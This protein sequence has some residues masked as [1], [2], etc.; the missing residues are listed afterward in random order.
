VRPLVGIP[1]DEW[2][3]RWSSC[4][5]A[6]PGTGVNRDQPG[7]PASGSLRFYNKR[8]TAEHLIE[9]GKQAVKRTRLSCHCFRSN[10]V[11]LA[12]SRLAYNLGDLCQRPAP[13]KRIEHRS[14]TSLQQGLGK[15]GRPL[16]KHERYYWLLLAEGHLNRQQRLERSWVGARCCR[17]ARTGQAA[18]ASGRPRG[19]GKKRGC[20]SGGISAIS[21]V[22]VRDIGPWTANRMKIVSHCPESVERAYMGFPF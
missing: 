17:Y 10:H 4:R 19:G 13:P 12:L 22:Q 8:G 18:T 9:E 20:E 2:W 1:H 3:R 14:L 16:V 7:D 15:T 5:R 21:A 11:R 6:V